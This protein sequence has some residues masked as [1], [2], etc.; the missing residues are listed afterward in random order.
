MAFSAIQGA[1]LIAMHAVAT[2]VLLSFTLRTYQF[3]ESDPKRRE[4]IEK[5]FQ[6][7]QF[8]AAQKNESEYVG[9]LVALL[10]FYHLRGDDTDMSLASTLAVVGQ[11]GYVWTRTLFGYPQIPNILMAVTRYGALVLLCLPLHQL[12]FDK[13]S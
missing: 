13:L 8:Q 1:S 9:L 11:I 10:L 12:A 7:Q 5:N 3:L 2:K 6:V 4:A